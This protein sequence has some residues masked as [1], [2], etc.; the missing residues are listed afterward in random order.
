MYKWREKRRGCIIRERVFYLS[1]GVKLS[2]SLKST[3]YAVQPGNQTQESNVLR[4]QHP[5]HEAKGLPHPPVQCF[6]L[7]QVFKATQNINKG[8]SKREV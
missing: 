5:S 8:E 4:A 2:V 3:H 7:T 1:C 6:A